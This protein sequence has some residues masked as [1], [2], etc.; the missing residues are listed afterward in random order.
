MKNPY[1]PCRTATGDVRIDESLALP[2]LERVVLRVGHFPLIA[3]TTLLRFKSNRVSEN[4]SSFRIGSL[5]NC[6]HEQ[7]KSLHKRFPS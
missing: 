4:F 2:L 6:K 3:T 5:F 1:M 7:R